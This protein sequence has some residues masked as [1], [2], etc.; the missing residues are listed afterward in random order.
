MSVDLGEA[1]RDS[2]NRLAS[3]AGF[4]SFLGVFVFTLVQNLVFLTALGG[5]IEFLIL[6][7]QRQFTEYDYSMERIIEAVAEEGYYELAAFLREVTTLGLDL[8][9]FVAIPLVLLLP[10]VFE[11]VLVVG[12]KAIGAS[13]Q[14]GGTELG[15]L[16]GG[17]ARDYVISVIANFLTVFIIA[18]ASLF[19]LIPGLIAGFLLF[20]VR[21]RVVLAG[22]GV[23]GALKASSD[24]AKANAL[25]TLAAIVVLY[26][27]WTVVML[28]T[29]FIPSV[30]L[31]AITGFL[32][33]LFVTLG[34]A[35][36]VSV[37]CRADAEAAC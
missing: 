31:L 21:E 29:A 5:L 28:L 25:P 36:T 33:A 22:D 16:T 1:V 35:V 6:E 9:I 30:P 34:I 8:P 10:F 17:L 20:Y 3:P 27:V 15:D 7:G 18:I 14:P 13:L 32:Q 23:F 37:Y 11:F 19:L 26:I 4:G 2:G 12:T 24:L